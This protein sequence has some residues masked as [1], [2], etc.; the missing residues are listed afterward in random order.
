LSR[1]NI[2]ENEAVNQLI[3]DAAQ[4]NLTIDIRKRTI[5]SFIKKQIDKKIK[6]Q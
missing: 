2:I 3:K 4:K 6:K 5:M 1:K